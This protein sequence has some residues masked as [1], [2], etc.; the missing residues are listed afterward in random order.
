MIRR[1]LRGSLS[2]IPRDAR[3]PILT[4]PLRGNKW[5]VGSATHGCWIGWYEQGA[6]RAFVESI[7]PGDVVFDIGANVGFFTLLAS[8]RVGEAGRVYAF[9]PLPRNL[10]YLDVHLRANGITNTEVI[11]LAVSDRSGTGRFSVAESAAM[12]KIS[13]EGSIEVR[14]ASLDELIA[15]CVVVRPHFMK[16]DVEGAESEVLAGAAVLLREEPPIIHLSAHGISQYQRC[17]STLQHLGYQIRV[18]HDGA[19]DGDYVLTCFPPAR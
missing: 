9:E 12:G 3:I 16:I 4:G 18:D 8:R 7:R 2:L 19:D 1:I 11:P 5:I 13:S 10:A 17:R 15:S 14:L 6:Q